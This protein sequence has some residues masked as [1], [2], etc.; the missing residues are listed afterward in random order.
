[1][2]FALFTIIFKKYVSTVKYIDLSYKVIDFHVLLTNSY[3][4][5]EN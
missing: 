3:L 4:R 1:M 2:K 5:G